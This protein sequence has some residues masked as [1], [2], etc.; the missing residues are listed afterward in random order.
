MST[1]R[2]AARVAADEERVWLAERTYGDDELNL[3][4]LV[5]ATTDGERYVRKER[6]LTSFADQRETPVSMVVARDQLG[7]VDDEDRE[8]YATEATRMAAE[9][10]PT[11]T[12]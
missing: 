9:H 11:D 12:I 7:A 4:I 3:I 2:D 5:Y 10:G 1:E 6:A 8:R